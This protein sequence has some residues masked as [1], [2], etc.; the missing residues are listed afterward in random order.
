ME[1]WKQI[2]GFTN[3]E[4]S[5]LG[6]IWNNIT[7]KIYEDK[8][9]NRIQYYWVHLVNDEGQLKTMAVHTLVAKYF[10]HNPNPDLYKIVWHGPGGY[11]DNWASNLSWGTI[12]MN[13]TI[14]KIRD[15]TYFYSKINQQK[16]K[17]FIQKQ[18]ENKGDKSINVLLKEFNK[19]NKKNIS[20]STYYR[21]Y[22]GLYD[23]II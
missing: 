1:S 17:E 20:Y 21:H 11:L 14:D 3:Y 18:K 22:T 7:N 4:V 16:Y 15:N 6:W 9:K 8:L 12:K 19:Y 5:D 23:T 2:E 13:N 10:V